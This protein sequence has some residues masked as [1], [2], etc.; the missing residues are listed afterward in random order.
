MCF[1]FPG[2]SRF[3]SR[4]RVNWNWYIPIPLRAVT[5]LLIL[6]MSLLTNHHSPVDAKWQPVVRVTKTEWLARILPELPGCRNDNLVATNRWLQHVFADRSKCTSFYLELCH[7]IAVKLQRHCHLALLLNH[8]SHLKT[9]FQPVST[10]EKNPRFQPVRNGAKPRGGS[11]RVFV[12][13]F[14][15]GTTDEQLQGHMS[16]AG[17]KGY[18][19]LDGASLW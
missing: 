12:R 1:F 2:T 5:S 6:D 17:Q 4:V 3:L 15:F 13:G 14:D 9:R 16:A 10:M 8:G 11:G 18:W 7:T 19:L